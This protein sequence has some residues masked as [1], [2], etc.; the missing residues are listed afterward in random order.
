[1]FLEGFLVDN[2]VIQEGGAEGVE[3]PRQGLVFVGLEGCGVS[4]NPKGIIRLSNSL[5]QVQKAVTGAMDVSSG[6]SDSV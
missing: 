6:E 2:V 4:V 5:Y 3:V 1:M